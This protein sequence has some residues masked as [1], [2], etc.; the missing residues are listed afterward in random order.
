MKKRMYKKEKKVI[1]DLRERKNI[2]IIKT[3][4]FDASDYDD[5]KLRRYVSDYSKATEAFNCYL[6]DK[7]VASK[8]TITDEE[9]EDVMA[10]T[11]KQHEILKYMFGEPKYRLYSR[12]K[13]YEDFEEDD[14]Y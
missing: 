8:R 2:K 1:V 10:K 13:G 11:I 9:F 6:I 3:D 7:E 5:E 4:E 12:E 14:D